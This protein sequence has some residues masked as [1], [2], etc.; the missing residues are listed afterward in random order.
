MSHPVLEHITLF[1]FTGLIVLTTVMTK[2][3]LHDRDDVPA[4]GNR[5]GLNVS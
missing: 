4:D 5:T 2:I 3:Q 1:S